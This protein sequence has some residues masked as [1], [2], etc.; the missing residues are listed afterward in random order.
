MSTTECISSNSRNWNHKNIFVHTYRI[1][2][3]IMMLPM[4][5][6]PVPN[7]SSCGTLWYTTTECYDTTKIYLWHH[8]IIRQMTKLYCEKIFFPILCTKSFHQYE[9]DFVNTTWLRGHTMD[10]VHTEC[11]SDRQN[12]VF[13]IIIKG[14]TNGAPYLLGEFYIFN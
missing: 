10:Y 5:A 13:F 9:M 3:S 12:Y 8:E 11:T 6:F 14:G 1:V 4:L 7:S 2:R